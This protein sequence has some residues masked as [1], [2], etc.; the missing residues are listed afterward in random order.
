[1]NE[2]Y[3]YGIKGM[4]WG[5]RRYQNKDGSYTEAGKKRNFK[6]IEKAYLNDI[7]NGYKDHNSGK[8]YRELARKN[9][10]LAKAIEPAVTSEQKLFRARQADAKLFRQEYDKLVKEYVKKNGEYP[11]GEDDHALSSKARHKVGM[12]NWDAQIETYRSVGRETV[13]NVLGKYAGERLNTFNMEIGE[14]VLRRYITIEAQVRNR[15]EDERNK[16]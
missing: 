13:D 9:P 8:T 6:K 4:K 11:D 7:K 12:P 3:H 16:N 10:D 2:L 15:E 1:M 14:R 5:V